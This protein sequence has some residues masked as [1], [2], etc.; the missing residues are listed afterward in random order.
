MGRT[1]ALLAL[2]FCAARAGAQQDPKTWH[3][4]IEPTFM[5]PQVSFPIAGAKDTV[6]VPGYLDEGGPEYFTKEQWNAAGLTWDKFKA[7]ATQNAIEKKVTGELVRNDKKVVLYAALNSD[8]PLTGTMILSP[9]FLKRFK[10]IFGSTIIVAIPNRFT[11]YVFPGLASDYKDYSTLVMQ[12][13]Y[14]STYPV[15][16][17]L[18]Q[19]S[20]AGI[21][22]IGEYR[23]DDDAAQ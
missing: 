14:N 17:E 20:P 13:Y 7:R 10:D 8:D 15:S 18:F 4:L 9:D 1:F 12:A 6:L 5:Q 19:I 16:L 11:V 23:E 3:I 2:A 22:A 21:K